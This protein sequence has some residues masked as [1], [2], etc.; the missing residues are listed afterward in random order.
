MGE[1]LIDI[2]G[3]GSVA[4]YAVGSALVAVFLAAVL[5]LFFRCHS[6]LC[7]KTFRFS[8][9]IIFGVIAFSVLVSLFR[10]IYYERYTVVLYGFSFCLPV[11]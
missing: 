10:P 1:K 9:E 11:P 5:L 8:A 3:K 4:Y 2:L 6:L 7:E